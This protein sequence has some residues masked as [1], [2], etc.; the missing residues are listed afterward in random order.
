VMLANLMTC[1]PDQRPG[2]AD[3]QL[4]TRAPSPGSLHLVC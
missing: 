4:L 2:A 3:Q 1:S